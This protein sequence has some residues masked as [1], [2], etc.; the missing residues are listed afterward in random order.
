ML[1]SFP[2][3]SA[4]G[5]ISRVQFLLMGKAEM[6]GIAAEALRAANILIAVAVLI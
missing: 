6:T 5:L 3:K 4:S 2:K 1:R